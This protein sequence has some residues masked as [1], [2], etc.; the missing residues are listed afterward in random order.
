MVH[1]LEGLDNLE[2]RTANVGEEPL[3]DKPMLG[4]ISGSS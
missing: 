1:W 3:I 2:Y 4:L